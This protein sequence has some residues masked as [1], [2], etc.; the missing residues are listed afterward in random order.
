[1]SHQVG[2]PIPEQ[3]AYVIGV[4]VT[5]APRRVAGRAELP[6]PAATTVRSR[7]PVRQVG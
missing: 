3:A 4:A 1:M 6:V 7:W 2:D 5:D